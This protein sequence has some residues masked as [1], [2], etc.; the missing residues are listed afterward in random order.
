[1]LGRSLRQADRSL[2]PPVGPCA[3][4]RRRS[5]R[6]DEARRRRVDRDHAQSRR[7]ELKPSDFI[8][9][10]G[11]VVLNRAGGALHFLFQR[12]KP[13]RAASSTGVSMFSRKNRRVC[14][15]AKTV[16]FQTG[17]NILVG[18]RNLR[19]AST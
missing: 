7:E 13:G 6:G 19:S 5:A 8:Q 10:K 11:P 2:W 17:R 4:H 9:R 1:M 14:F 12:A 18:A 16:P 15:V 3:A